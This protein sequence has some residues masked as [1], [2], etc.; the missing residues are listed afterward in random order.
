[1]RPVV[2]NDL[3]SLEGGKSLLE[4]SMGE[5]QGEGSSWKKAH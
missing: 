4:G 5:S 3:I 2:R 1:M